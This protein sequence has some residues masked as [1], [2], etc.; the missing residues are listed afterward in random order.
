MSYFSWELSLTLPLLPLFQ[1][2]AD[3]PFYS[4]EDKG[5]DEDDDEESEEDSDGGEGKK[6]KKSPKKKPYVMDAD[7]RLLLRNCK[8]LLQSRNASVS[9]LLKYV[10]VHVLVPEWSYWLSLCKEYSCSCVGLSGFLV[11]PPPQMLH[12]LYMYL[13][14]CSWCYL[15][16]YNCVNNFIDSYMYMI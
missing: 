7:H 9:W 3:A 5:S 12:V 16:T 8:P 6:K 4:D 10:I 15:Y 11:N 1:E 2:L 13:Y 14:A